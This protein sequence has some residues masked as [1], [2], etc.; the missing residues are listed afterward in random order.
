MCVGVL[1]FI[2]SSKNIEIVILDQT[3][4]PSSQ[5]VCLNTNVYQVRPTEGLYRNNFDQKISVIEKSI[6]IPIN[7]PSNW[8]PKYSISYPLV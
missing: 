6:L 7:F 8:A 2:F 1:L 5:I 3:S 4:D